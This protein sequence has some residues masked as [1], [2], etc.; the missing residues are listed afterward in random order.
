MACDMQVICRTQNQPALWYHGRNYGDL[1]MKTL[2]LQLITVGL[3]DGKQG[4]FVGLPLLS[5]QD[6]DAGGQVENLWFSDVKHVPDSLTMDE[7]MQLVGK[8][9]S[10]RMDTVQ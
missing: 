4:I 2:E 8:Q 3:E 5:Q 10:D 6:A 1:G 7:L 9:L